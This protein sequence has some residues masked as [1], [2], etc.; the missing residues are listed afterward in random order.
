[1][2]SLSSLSASSPEQNKLTVEAQTKS[3]QQSSSSK[4][5]S[6]T[7]HELIQKIKSDNLNPT[8]TSASISKENP[9][10][11]LVIV[12]TGVVSAGKSSIVQ[13]LKSVDPEF[14]EEDLD[15]RRDPE[16]PTTAKMTEEMIDDTI[17]RSLQGKKTI[18]SLFKAS[19]FA[20]RITERMAIEKDLASIPVKTVLA[21]CPLEEIPVRLEARNKAAEAQGGD[22]K[23]WRNPSVAIDQFASLYTK[24]I[25]GKE[26]VTRDKAIKYFNECFDKMILHDNH[27]QPP[28][29]E[30]MKKDNEVKEADCQKFL[31]KLGFDNPSQT[32]ILVA[33]KF[34]YDLIVDTTLYRSSSSREQLVRKMLQ[35]M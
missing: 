25:A 2:S 29:A 16:T 15:L 21:H 11:G 27:G 20:K 22:P 1:M 3:K 5:P 14:H 24:S 31:K 28:P 8:A 12:L 32:E 18:I 17:N 13:A 7:K 23:N 4:A 35:S 34:N 33:P 6:P 9:K 19:E 30:Q 10:K 26:K